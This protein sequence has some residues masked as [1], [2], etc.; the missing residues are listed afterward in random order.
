MP[1]ICQASVSASSPSRAPHV[2]TAAVGFSPGYRWRSG[3]SSWGQLLYST[4]GTMTV[5]GASERWVVPPTQALWLPPNHD[6]AVSLSG[7]GA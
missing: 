1:I 5:E 3:G 2:R 6:N 7:Q 4:R